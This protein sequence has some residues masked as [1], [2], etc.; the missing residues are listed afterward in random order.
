MDLSKYGDGALKLINKIKETVYNPNSHVFS[1]LREL[2]AIA[3][4][5][6]NDE[7][8]GIAY[9]HYALAYYSRGKSKELLHYLKLAISCLVSQDEKEI[10]AAA[11]N[12]FAVEAKTNGCFEVALDYYLTAHHLMEDEKSSLSYASSGANIADLLAQM[13]EYKEAYKYTKFIKQAIKL[14]EKDNEHTVNP[15]NI[16]LSHINLG[17]IALNCNKREEA[18]KED[19]I[20][21]EIGASAIYDYGG[22]IK[23][24]Y[25]IFKLRLA[26]DANEKKTIDDLVMELVSDISSG[27]IL[28]ELVQ[29]ILDIFDALI[30]I[31]DLK[32]ANHL[33][34]TLENKTQMNSYA[35]MLFSQLKTKYYDA[36]GDKEKCM[37]CYEER[38]HYMHEH[39]ETQNYI[40]YESITLM[41]MLEELRREEEKIRF[42]NIAIQKNAETDSLT[43]IPNR[44][45]LD[46]HLD[47]YFSEAK[48]NQVN[49]GTGIVDIDCFKDYNDTYGHIQGDNCLIDVAKTLEE[50]ASKH[51]LF[52]ARYGG[53][54]FVLIYYDHQNKEIQSIEE[55]ILN[56]ASVSVTHGFYNAVPDIESKIYDYLSKADQELYK[57]KKKSGVY[58]SWT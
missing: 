54:E 40:Y 30:K 41:E 4:V 56:S 49:L 48:K 27:L 45:A 18:L 31:G 13:G 42:E 34:N 22:M 9:Y 15:A 25:L 50:V 21:E 28:S 38:N 39:L 55:E 47:Y 26:L 51:G 19:M 58:D 7:L 20:I 43:G 44:Y 5:S 3:K 6:E 2:E 53:D 32:N 14:F 29:E 12:V 24:Y 37:E 36:V 23:L 17:L 57:N 1:R 35:K 33:L 46:R 52:V 11:Y 10:L 8:L 16:V